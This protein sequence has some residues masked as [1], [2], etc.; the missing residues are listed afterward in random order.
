MLESAAFVGSSES[1]NVGCSHLM[2]KNAA[3]WIH[4]LL[5]YTLRESVYKL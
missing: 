1:S 3:R 5:I 2:E 4:V